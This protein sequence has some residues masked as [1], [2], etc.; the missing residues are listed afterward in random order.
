MKLDH[1]VR[2]TVIAIRMTCEF[3]PREKNSK[4]KICSRLYPFE[5]KH[6]T[7][8]LRSALRVI[9]LRNKKEKHS[10]HTHYCIFI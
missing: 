2:K 10:V 4:I 9:L 7:P 8:A 1:Y 5:R 6:G 3:I